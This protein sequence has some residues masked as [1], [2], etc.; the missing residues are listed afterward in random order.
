MIM[1]GCILMSSKEFLEKMLEEGEKHS[2]K[3]VFKTIGRINISFA[4]NSFVKGST[5]DVFLKLFSDN[6]DAKRVAA[7]VTARAKEAGG[8]MEAV[9]GFYY[10]IPK[11]YLLGFEAE[12]DKARFV[13]RYGEEEDFMAIYDAINELSLPLNEDFWVACKSIDSL[14]AVAKGE[15]GK[16]TNQSGEDVYPTFLV[17]T[18]KF[19]NE[20]TAR[21][22]VGGDSSSSSNANSDSAYSN[23][24]REGIYPTVANFEE[25]FEHI[26][27][28]YN[29]MKGGKLPYEGAPALPAPLIDPTIKSYL[30]DMYTCETEDID[31]ALAG[32]PF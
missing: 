22:A 3:P 18:E 13:S 1:K 26:Q 19:A 6:N 15:D 9:L 23:M 11:E 5:R 30:A 7:E 24:V 21:D 12:Y 27:K 8:K 29:I 32:V 16:Y 17:P 10:R 25:Q 31:L 4:Y 14:S 28:Y 2:S 20:Q